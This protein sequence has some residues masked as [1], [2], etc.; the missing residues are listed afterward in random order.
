[1]KRIAFVSRTLFMGMIAAV[2]LLSGCGTAPS[3]AASTPRGIP[4]TP[5][6]SAAVNVSFD[7]FW[8]LPNGQFIQFINNVFVLESTDGNI[9]NTGVFTHTNT[10]FFCNFDPDVYADFNYTAVNS[11]TIRVTSTGNEWMNGNWSK[12]NI[13][14]T[15]NGHPLVGYWERKTEDRITILFISPFG[16]GDEFVCDT[17]YNLTDRTDIRYDEDNH[18]EFRWII[19]GEG[20]QMSMTYKYVFDGEDL[21]VGIG[22]DVS[23]YNRY[24]KK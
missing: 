14:W 6:T 9:V 18:S 23:K 16:W 20:F 15:S 17:E 1:M 24:V 13:V 12:L 10:Q 3:T 19:F 11:E 4:V 8:K 7:G 5:V 2:L 21:L 22:D